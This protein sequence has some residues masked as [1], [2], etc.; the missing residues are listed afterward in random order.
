ME[1]KALQ[2]FSNGQWNPN[3]KWWRLHSSRSLHWGGI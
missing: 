2:H 3:E 1:W